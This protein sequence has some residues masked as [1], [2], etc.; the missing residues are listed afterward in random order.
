MTVLHLDYETFSRVD[1]K[2]VGGY[3]Y[4]EDE[5]TEILCAGYAFDEEPVEVWTPAHGAFPERICTHIA[6]GG[7]VVAHNAEFE[8]VITNGTAGKKLG[9]PEIDIRQCYCTAVAARSAGLPG[10]LDGA[11]FAMGTTAKDDE[12][13]FVMMQVSKPRKPSKDNPADRFTPEAFPEKFLKLYIYC[14]R[15][16]EAE[17]DLDKHLPRITDSEMEYYAIDQE[18][19]TRGI[20]IDMSS[21]DDFAFLI[22]EYKRELETLCMKWTGRKP[23]QREQIAEWVRTHGYPQL[24]DMQAPTIVEIVKGNAPDKVKD[25][26]KLYSTYNMKAVSK[27]KA[28]KNMVCADGRVRGCHVFYGAGPGRWASRLLQTQNMMRPLIQ[29]V[30]VAFDAAQTR[31][32]DWIKTLWGDVDPMKVF[33]SCTRGTIAAP[34]GKKLISMD[35]AGIE[36][37]WTSWVFGEKW[38]IRAFN[39][40]DTIIP[41]KFDE[42]GDPLRAGPDMYKLT[43]S[44]LFRIEIE[45]VTKEMRQRAKPID[46]AFGF[47]GGVGAL[48]TFA[49]A[50]NVDLDEL[51]EMAYKSLSE[52]AI[53]YGRYMWQ[54]MGNKHG[55]KERTLIGL[56]GIKWTWRDKHTAHKE[57]WKQLKDSA[58]AAVR[59]PGQVFGL[60]NKKILFK[61]VDRWLVMLLPS[62]RKIR[63]LDPEV[64]GVN[65]DA[66]CTYMGVDTETRQFMRTHSY[67]GKWTQNGAEGGCRDLLCHGL[68]NLVADR[69]D[70]TMLVHDEIVLETLDEDQ[71]EFALKCYVRKP[72]WALDFPLAAEGYEAQRYRKD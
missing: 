67:G 51:A 57:G 20:Y 3:R 11:C 41:G 64:H 1:L 35:Y 69:Y 71:L 23:T 58:I 53:D 10:D 36:S 63:Y 34:P 25:V 70:P 5:S 60:P 38:K 65:D 12:G 4:A 29:D 44:D 24:T 72:P 17:R 22:D 16:V 19:N 59:Y 46:L 14:G 6:E 43:Y 13:H 66:V 45:K 61:V 55:L 32:L 18:L 27:Y 7:R 2:K 15:D 52:R 31:D 9:I 49:S 30:D 68:K 21:V 39:A 8:R 62:G 42:K 56:E 33:A 28:I 48:I 37:R 54:L 47:E 40:Y 26:L 50:Y